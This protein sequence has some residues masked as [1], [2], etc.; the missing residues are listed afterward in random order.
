MKAMLVL[1]LFLVP[2]AYA[3]SLQVLQS[4][5]SPGFSSAG[6]P[7]CAAIGFA[8]HG[9]IYGACRYKIY[10]VSCRYCQLAAQAVCD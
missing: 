2:P 10:T 8:S 9:T 4:P 3:D 6:P 7:A 1:S 5:P